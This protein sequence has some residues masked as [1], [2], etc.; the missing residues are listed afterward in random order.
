MSCFEARDVKPLGVDLVKDTKDKIRSIE[1]KLLAAQSR[2]NKYT[3]N[4]GRYGV[5]NWR[6]FTSQGITHEESQ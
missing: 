4:K 1:D 5:S 2:Q 6:K 3:N